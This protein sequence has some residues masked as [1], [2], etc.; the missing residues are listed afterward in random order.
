MTRAG[1]L[2][3]GADDMGRR[4][5]SWRKHVGRAPPVVRT[6]QRDGQSIQ[7]VVDRNDGRIAEFPLRPHRQER[8]S[9][10]VAEG[11]EVNHVC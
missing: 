10:P 6:V 4:V 11:G 2:N 5:W 9:A 1:Y 3:Q 7:Q 8:L